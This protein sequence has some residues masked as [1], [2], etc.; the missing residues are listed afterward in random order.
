MIEMLLLK[1]TI[2]M[3]KIDNYSFEINAPCNMDCTCEKGDYSPVCGTDGMTYATACYAGC[4]A[5]SLDPHNNT[6]GTISKTS[7]IM[8]PVHET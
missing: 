7:N 5:V 8:T 3:M 1:Q 6:V 2:F 4:E